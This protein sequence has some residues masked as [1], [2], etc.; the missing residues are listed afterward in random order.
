MPLET[1]P[2]KLDGLLLIRGRRFGDNRGWFY[3]SFSR[4][5]LAELGLT[6]DFMQDNQSYS[7]QTG[8]IRGLH[9]QLPPFGQSKLIRALR[10]RILSCAVDIRR[11]SPTFGQHEKVLLSADSADQFFIPQGFA[12]G[13]C[14][15][16]E[17]CE[18]FYKVDA[19]YSPSHERGILWNDPALAIEWVIPAQGATLSPRD[20]KHPRLAEQTDLLA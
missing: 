2:L 19:P 7:A 9:Y 20:E 18:I 16:E 6:N 14:T 17:N 13:F 4:P 3:E 5:A 15:L 10:G 11:S 8:T 12:H 1:Q